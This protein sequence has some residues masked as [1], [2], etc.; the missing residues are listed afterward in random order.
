[1]GLSAFYRLFNTQHPARVVILLCSAL[2]GRDTRT[3]PEGWEKPIPD[4][5]WPEAMISAVR[6]DASALAADRVIRTIK[7]WQ[8]EAID[9]SD[10]RAQEEARRLLKKL[11]EALSPELALEADAFDVAATIHPEPAAG[12]DY[13]VDAL[14]LPPK[15]NLRR[16]SRL[17]TPR[18]AVEQADEE[19]TDHR[20]KRRRSFSAV[21]ADDAILEEAEADSGSYRR[22]NTGASMPAEGEFSE[23]DEKP[24]F[25][26]PLPSSGPSNAA[27]APAEDPDG[28]PTRHIDLPDEVL[29]KKADSFIRDLGLG[30][31]DTDP[32]PRTGMTPK[33]PPIPKDD[34]LHVDEEATHALRAKEVAPLVDDLALEIGRGMGAE[35]LTPMEL[36]DRRGS[37]APKPGVIRRR[38]TKSRRLQSSPRPRAAMHHVRALYYVLMPFA[39]ELIPLG[40]ERRSRRFWGRWREV[41]G[42]RGVRREFIEDLLRAANDARTL[43]CELIAEVQ[44]VDVRSVYALVEK[45]EQSGDLEDANGQPVGTPE[46]QRGPLVG[47]SVRVEGVPLDEDES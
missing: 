42:D 13:T 3:L 44:S 15:P 9:D 10:T 24:T 18:R 35:P 7:L 1:V 5:I 25:A 36:P 4:S 8:A 45:L 19:E 17:E 34:E 20:P 41:A 39:G 46:R 6:H 14:E 30:N 27:A 47:A 12:D 32:P 40:Y 26:F 37:L 2:V 21:E 31:P 43:V 22:V 29:A 23:E 28:G 11:A 16:A 38:S 33:P